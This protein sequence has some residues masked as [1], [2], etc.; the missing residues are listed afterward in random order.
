MRHQH[1]YR[2]LTS[3]IGDNSDGDSDFHQRSFSVNSQSYNIDG[4]ED[5]D[6][7]YYESESSG[8]IG[9]LSRAWEFVRQQIVTHDEDEDDQNESIERTRL[10]S[11]HNIGRSRV[12][13]KGGFNLLRR[14]NLPVRRRRII[15]MQDWFHT[16]INMPWKTLIPTYIIGIIFAK[17]ARPTKRKKTLLFSDKAVINS[18]GNGHSLLQ[19]RVADAR[20]HQL[21]EAHSRMIL[22]E[23]VHVDGNVN[24]EK[25]ELETKDDYLF[26]ALP[27]I[28]THEIQEDSRL[29]SLLNQEKARFEIVALVE[30]IIPS[31]GC[32]LQVSESYCE[33]EISRGYFCSMIKKDDNFMNS[34]GKSSRRKSL[35]RWQVDLSLLSK[36]V[37]EDSCTK[38][39]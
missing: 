32:S 19:V 23:E 7:Y 21:V 16:A 20:K 14:I 38:E 12:V 37:E 4:Y 26:L 5:D 35:G 24:I 10:L 27:E 2:A 9:S 39:Q 8:A 18:N 25:T 17:L 30:G 15:F 3:G 11:F 6:S 28:I 22:L 1:P 31:T 36:I 34:N 33:N 29:H 13:Q